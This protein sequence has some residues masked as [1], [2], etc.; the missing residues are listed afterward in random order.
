MQA[1]IILLKVAI[2]MIV[3]GICIYKFIR[4]EDSGLLLCMIGII[5]SLIVLT[6]M[7]TSPRAVQRETNVFIQQKEYI[8]NHVSD[9]TY[10]DAALT[11]KKIEL[12]E[13]LIEAQYQYEHYRFWT[14]YDESIMELELIQ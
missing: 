9:N 3:G 13:W 11:T 7:I 2:V 6:I 10:E 1:C 4:H 8:E 5:L 14:F 12:N